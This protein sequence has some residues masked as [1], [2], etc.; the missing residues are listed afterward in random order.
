MLMLIDIL[1]FV[2][3]YFTLFF[4]GTFVVSVYGAI[5]FAVAATVFAWGEDAW[6]YYLG[7]LLLGVA[8]NFSFSAGTVMLTESYLV[9]RMC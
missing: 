9:R 3:L 5:L 1:Y 4:S 2:N 7:M 6:N 8:W